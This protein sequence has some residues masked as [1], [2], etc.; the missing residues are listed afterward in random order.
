MQRVPHS[1]V[2]I[3]CARVHVEAQ[4]LMQF[5]KIPPTAVGGLFHTQ[6]KNETQ[7]G[8]L[9]PTDRSRWIVHTSPIKKGPPDEISASTTVIR[10]LI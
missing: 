2:L 9:N 6:P 5:E 8:F 4:V 3:G 1:T 10:G 7:H